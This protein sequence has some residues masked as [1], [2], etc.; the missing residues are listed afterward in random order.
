[1]RQAAERFQSGAWKAI[2][3]PNVD[4]HF[5]LGTGRGPAT[6]EAGEETRR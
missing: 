2:E 5:G 6:A 4:S 3:Q 1:V